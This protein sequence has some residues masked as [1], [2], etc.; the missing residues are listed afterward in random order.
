VLNGLQYGCGIGRPDCSVTLHVLPANEG[1]ITADERTR[2]ADPCSSRV[3][4]Y[5]VRVVLPPWHKP[6]D[7]SGS[8]STGDQ[9]V[10]L[11]SA[12]PYQQKFVG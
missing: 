6:M 2:T 12:G 11:I 1:K 9:Q 3:G 8:S 7:K 4:H 10:S 5:G